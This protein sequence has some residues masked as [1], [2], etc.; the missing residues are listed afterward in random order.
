MSVPRMP[1]SPALVTPMLHALDSLGCGV[2]AVSGALA[3]GR[4]GLDP[5]G[6]VVLGLVTA[7]GRGTI[8]DVLLDRHPIFWLANPTY[9]QAIVAA[10]AAR[11]VATGAG[12]AVAAV[13][14]ASIVWGLQLPTFHLDAE[15]ER[16]LHWRDRRATCEWEA[17]ARDGGRRA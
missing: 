8:R 10:G 3:A 6:G 13:W 11:G 14:L 12:M 7:M 17:T 2:F 9:V 5:L 1:P 16:H 4:K 15:G